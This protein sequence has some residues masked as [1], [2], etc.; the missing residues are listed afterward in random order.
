MAV[1]FDLDGTLADSEHLSGAAWDRVLAGYDVVRT[2]E[3][4]RAVT[5]LSFAATRDHFAQRTG[6]LPSAA[7]LWPQYSDHLLAS[8]RKGVQPFPDA[9][10]LLLS[11]T[12][13][14]IPVALASSSPRSRVTATL[15]GMGLSALEPRSVA[16]DEVPLAKPAPDGFLAAARLL[17]VPAYECIAV[18]DSTPGVIAARAAGMAV[19]AV[20]RAPWADLSDATEVVDA[21]T[22]TTLDPYLRNPG[23][24]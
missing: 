19:V 3:D 7:Q 6:T 10:A 8:L 4:D 24:A 14:R 20:R 13:R 23:Q 18:E 5:G 12:K 15:Q 22:P 1:V 2:G 17:G 21:L 16:G 9:V 11:L